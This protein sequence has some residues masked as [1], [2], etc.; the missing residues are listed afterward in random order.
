MDNTYKNVFVATIALAALDTTP[1]V[2]PVSGADGREGVQHLLAYVRGCAR[3][4]Q[5]VTSL[6][7][8]GHLLWS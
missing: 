6:A 8:R 7:Y 3:L 5:V 2:V 1:V 4:T